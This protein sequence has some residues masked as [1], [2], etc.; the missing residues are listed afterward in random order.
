MKRAFRATTLLTKCHFHGGQCNCVL[1]DNSAIGI[2]MG[3][4]SAVIRYFVK[5]LMDLSV[6]FFIKQFLKRNFKSGCTSKKPANYTKVRVARFESNRD[7]SFLNFW[8]H[9]LSL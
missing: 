1:D 9:L 3:S 5:I 7:R 4:Y 8:A 2:P 6:S